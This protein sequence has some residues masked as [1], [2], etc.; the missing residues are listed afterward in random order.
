M[1]HD[2]DVVAAARAL[3]ARLP[4]KYSDMTVELIELMVGFLKQLQERGQAVIDTQESVLERCGDDLPEDMTLDQAVELGL[5][6]EEALLDLT[7]SEV[8][9]VR[10]QRAQMVIMAW[11]AS[12]GHPLAFDRGPLEDN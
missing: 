5:V 3:V 1:A 4:K 11:Q 8:E 9:W 10:L 6:P 12:A 2:D 7:D